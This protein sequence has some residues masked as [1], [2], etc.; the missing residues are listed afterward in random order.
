MSRFCIFVAFT[1]TAFA[2]PV[3]T[4]GKKIFD[5]QCA[6]CH[7]QSGGGGR[8][9]SLARPKLEKAPDDAALQHVISNGIEPEMP[10]AW[11]LNPHEV[12]SVAAYVRSLGRSEEHTSE[13]QSH[14]N[15]V[16]RLLLE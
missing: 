6:L 15:L 3:E 12:E 4:V 11:Q 7:G 16:C 14:V 5:S 9:P 8:G 1:W 2:Q 13:L 10:G